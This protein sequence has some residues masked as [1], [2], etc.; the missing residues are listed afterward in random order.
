MRAWMLWMAWLLVVGLWVARALAGRDLV[1]EGEAFPGA[2]P[3]VSTTL[4]VEGDLELQAEN[5]ILRLQVASLETNVEQLRRV[6]AEAEG[7]AKRLGRGL[8]RAIAQREAAKEAKPL[9]A[10]RRGSGSGRE[11]SGGNEGR[12]TRKP[13]AASGESTGTLESKARLNVLGGEI[14]VHGELR[15][16]SAEFLSGTVWIDLLHNGRRID[17]ASYLAEIG[18]REGHQYSARF[19]AF[20]YHG[21]TFSARARFEY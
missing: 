13:K 19:Y 15:N 2:C 17:S 12:R 7:E 20:G 6:A 21:G 1:E 4:D 14:V 18:G 16:K 9:L 5:R 8:E 3:E 11:P 10:L